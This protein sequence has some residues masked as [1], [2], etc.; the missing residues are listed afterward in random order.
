WVSGCSIT[1]LWSLGNGEL[2]LA[3][4]ARLLYMVVCGCHSLG[5]ATQG[6]VSAHL[7]V[8]RSGY[9]PLLSSWECQAESVHQGAERGEAGLDSLDVRER[10]QVEPRQQ[11]ARAN[12]RLKE[13]SQIV[14]VM[15]PAVAAGPGGMGRQRGGRRGVRGGRLRGRRRRSGGW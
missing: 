14:E 1:Y 8:I 7:R 5:L 13:Q 2:L 15:F 11:Q 3:L 4:D 9:N 12:I 6:K 10:D